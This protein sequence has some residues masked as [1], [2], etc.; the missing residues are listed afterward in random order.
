[1]INKREIVVLNNYAKELDL[2]TKRLESFLSSNNSKGLE[3]TKKKI[4]KLQKKF[5]SFLNHIK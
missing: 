2:E 1:M 3:N 5:N 4:L